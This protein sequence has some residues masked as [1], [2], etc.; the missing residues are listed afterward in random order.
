MSGKNE[1]GSID[2]KQ[3][4]VLN[5]PL[6]KHSSERSAPSS[7]PP[8][9][10]TGTC[11]SNNPIA[12][13]VTNSFLDFSSSLGTDL[14]KIGLEPGQ[15]VCLEASM[16]KSAID[17]KI[18]DVPRVKLEATH[19]KALN[20]VGIDMLKRWAAE[21]ELEGKRDRVIKPGEGGESW[22]R[23]SGDIGAK[24]PRSQVRRL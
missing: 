16:W 15:R 2:V 14:R 1:Q 11:N 10:S 17:N 23:E 13:I 7:L 22:A 5:A 18:R 21:P 12:A 20:S 19:V 6:H 4:N 24:D 8:T 9:L 3:K